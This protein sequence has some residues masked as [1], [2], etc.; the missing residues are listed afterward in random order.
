MLTVCFGM[1]SWLRRNLKVKHFS[2]VGV[3]IFFY[4]I[5]QLDISKL[6]GVIAYTNIMLVAVGMAIAFSAFIV[7]SIRWNHIIFQMLGKKGSARSVISC[8]ISSTML[9]LITPGRLG[10]LLYRTKY[11]KSVSSVSAGKAFSTVAVDRLFDITLFLIASIIGIILVVIV[12]ETAVM[13]ILVF[14]AIMCI[15]LMLVFFWMKR[16][17]AVDSILRV[18]F[19]AIVPNSMKKRIKLNYN[20]F[21]IAMRGMGRWQI[22]SALVFSLLAFMVSIASYFFVAISIGMSV[23][24]WYLAF[25]VPITYMV[26]LIPISVSGL[27]TREASYIFLFSLVG[28][29]PEVSLLF[30]IFDMLILNWGIALASYF[31][32][33]AIRGISSN[34]PNL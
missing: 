28:I 33:Q 10:E 1:V 21:F 17:G 24:I 31:M 25:V 22:A 6:V 11:V 32:A 29:Q 27:G 30:S 12:F 34:G 5:L 20:D 3:I 15:M 16:R 18:F 4:I 9:G 13:E 2:I 19:R 23:P 8:W 26:T 7:R 14:L